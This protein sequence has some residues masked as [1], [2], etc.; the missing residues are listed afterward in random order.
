VHLVRE[1][2]PRIHWLNV[3][4]LTFVPLVAMVG[5]WTTPL[6]RPTLIWAILYYNFTGLGIT[7]GYHR[8]FAHRAYQANSLT[9]FMM[10]LAG[11]GALEGSI[12]WWCG[13]HRVHHRYTDTNKDPYNAQGGFW[14]AHIGWMMIKPDPKNHA[15]ADIR[16]L[17]ADPIIRW[18]HQYYLFIGPFMAFV[19]PT[20]V[21]GL[22]WGDWVGGY[23]FAGAMRLFFVH[24]S[25]F[26]VNSVAHYF[27]EHTFDD[28]RSPRDHIVTALLTFGEGYHNFHHEFP[29][30]Y[31]N[32][33]QWYHYDPTKWLIAGLSAIGCTWALKVFPKN[34]IKRGVLYMREKK[35]AELRGAIVPPKSAA[36]LPAMSWQEYVN[37]VK[38]D[39]KPF[40]VVDGLVHDVSA[41][42]PTH[43]GGEAILRGYFGT[44]ATNTFKGHTNPVVYKHSHAAENLLANMRVAR[45]EG[46]TPGHTTPNEKHE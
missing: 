15:K 17:N 38:V 14:Y 2:A 28:D 11:S 13:G 31:R 19:L 39:H 44:D 20:L 37:A 21:A 26:C 22:G 5:L 23:F 7:A 18:Q 42:L 10:M 12:K 29:N 33:I 40:V 46:D 4:I 6:Q 24:H 35:L 32:G 34:E 27:G 16:D 25:T 9:R 45:I 36:S 1:W 41:F 3:F 8:L 30:D 43:P